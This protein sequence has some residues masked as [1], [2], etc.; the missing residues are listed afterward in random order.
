[1][2]HYWLYNLKERV[3]KEELS[4]PQI[5]PCDL[6]ACML[7]TRHGCFNVKRLLQ[8]MFSLTLSLHENCVLLS[9]K[10]KTFELHI[11]SGKDH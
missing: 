8:K 5:S 11:T 10:F 1:M 2:Q 3:E 4:Y 6:Y 7:T 9:K